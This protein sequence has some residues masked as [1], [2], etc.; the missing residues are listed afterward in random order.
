MAE[1]KLAPNLPGKRRSNFGHPT[2]TISSR[3]SARYR[4]SCWIQSIRVRGGRPT[5]QRRGA[6]QMA[7]AHPDEKT[8]SGF[9][10]M[11]RT[12]QDVRTHMAVSGHSRRLQAPSVTSGPLQ[13][14]D[15]ARPVLR[16]LGRETVGSPT[17][18]CWVRSKATHLDPMS[19]SARFLGPGGPRGRRLLF[20]CKTRVLLLSIVRWAEDG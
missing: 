10:R 8:F 6:A 19:I 1:A 7:P 14:T 3:P 2:P 4:W 11:S 17:S 9:V 13:S 16:K 12:R 15:I 18:Q 20:R 5:Q